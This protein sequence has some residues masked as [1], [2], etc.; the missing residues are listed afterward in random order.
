M[1]RICFEH[2]SRARLLLKYEPQTELVLKAMAALDELLAVS[3]PSQNIQNSK[4]YQ[5]I[6]LIA[7]DG[8][9]IREATSLVGVAPQSVYNVKAKYPGRGY[10]EILSL[11]D[12]GQSVP[13]APLP[14]PTID[15]L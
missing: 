10:A 2:V 4:V 13:V 12:S 7:T 14:P 1:N 6:K 3:A 9:T 5:A 11:L 8:L 15:D